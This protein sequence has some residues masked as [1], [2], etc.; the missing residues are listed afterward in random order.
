MFAS[1]VVLLFVMLCVYFAEAYPPA[2]R[3]RNVL[4]AAALISMVTL[5]GVRNLTVGTDTENYVQ[6][7]EAI[8]DLPSALAM[9]IIDNEY[10]FWILNWAAH[11]IYDGYVSLLSLVAVIVCGC[12]MR[13]ILNNSCNITISVF[14]FLTAGF[15]TFFF[16][17]AR[18]AIACAICALAIPH[19]INKK[20]KPYI[21]L[22]I[23]AVLFHKTAIVMLPVYFVTGAAI[24]FSRVFVYALIGTISALF[25][26]TLV[27]FGAT[28]DP[29]YADYAT[30]GDGGGFLM[31]AFTLALTIFFF[32]F[33]R[34]VVLHREQYF[35]LLNML[36]FG[37]IIS[38]I[39]SVFRIA[40][41]GILRLSIYFNVATL[42][43][44]PI[45][46]VNFPKSFVRTIG[47]YFFGLGYTVFFLLSIDRFGDLSPYVVNPALALGLI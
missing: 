43:L 14:V 16:N 15:Y 27:Q 8:T 3:A 2:A 46:F 30:S 23:T 11:L 24:S 26:D 28:V 12:Y 42:F 32:A 20:F 4:L 47:V 45:V 5:A 39:S 1:I 40:P 13:S 41:S 38:C 36:M 35:V 19:L 37:A 29:R 44:W 18:Q 21:F 22:I 25:L 34:N 17:G 33:R 7:F 10:G 9:G 6:F 31:V